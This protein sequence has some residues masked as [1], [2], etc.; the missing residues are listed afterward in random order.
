M[1]STQ[2]VARVKCIITGERRLF[3]E[4]PQVFTWVHLDLYLGLFSTLESLFFHPSCFFPP[5]AG[6]RLI[7][8][9]WHL[10]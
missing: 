2:P 7:F 1:E 3:F 8:K 10:D 4:S 5:M 6:R 9:M